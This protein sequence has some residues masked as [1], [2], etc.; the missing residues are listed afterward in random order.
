MTKF[1]APHRPGRAE[2]HPR[3]QAAG[4]EAGGAGRAEADRR[5]P[6]KV[7]E[8]ALARW[9]WP[10][11]GGAGAALELALF[12][13]PTRRAPDAAPASPSRRRPPRPRP[14]PWPWCRRGSRSPTRTARSLSPAS[15]M[16]TRPADLDR[17]C[18]QGG[19]RGGQGPRRHRRRPEPRRCALARELPQRRRAPSRSRA[20]RRF[21][22][23]IRSTSAA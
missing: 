6:R 11:L 20:S 22:T 10:L 19:V 1:I 7:D 3:P 4:R 13:W 9:L 23:A 16:T 21:S 12:F 15:F 2:Q 5:L 17:Q 14:P 8:P 18:A